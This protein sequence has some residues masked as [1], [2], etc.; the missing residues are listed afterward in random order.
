MLRRL[1]IAAAAALFSLIL[2]EGALRLFPPPISDRLF[3]VDGRFGWFHI[4]GRQG[5]YRSSE[6]SVFI[7]INSHGLRDSEHGYDKPEG[8]C[9]VLLLGD[10]FVEG[11]QVPL[12]QTVG[13]QL[14]G[15]LN[16]PGRTSFE[17]INGG[18]AG[19][20]SDRELLFY[21]AEG[22]AYHPDLVAL[23]FFRNDP[24]D[25]T[26]S[27]YASIGPRKLR[28]LAASPEENP[29]LAAMARSWLWDRF[30]TVRLGALAWVRIGG[31]VHPGPPSTGE[32]DSVYRV[33]VPADVEA[34]WNLTLAR[35]QELQDAVEEDGAQLILVDVPDVQSLGPIRSE[36][37]YSM[38]QVS[39]R[40]G[41]IADGLGIAYLDLLPAFSAQEELTPATLYWPKD[42]HWTSAGHRLA[43]QIVSEQ[44]ALANRSAEDAGAVARP[45]TACR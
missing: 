37:G 13:R 27:P 12:A 18:V 38:D 43:A 45:R 22:R 6:V 14:E 11:M 24:F 30:I 1:A 32:P 44:L 10:S 4:P 33:P 35:L 8:T 19:F 9:R 28:T 40:L 7:T 36:P 3:Q 25:N 17:V 34:A 29:G 42:E 39:L 5:W 23:F 41:E 16:G 31:L 15:L 21:Q 26:S 20:G 2:F